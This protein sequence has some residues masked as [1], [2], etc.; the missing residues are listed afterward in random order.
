MP[1]S[2]GYFLFVK[3]QLSKLE[4]ITYRK[5]MGEYIVY[6][7]DKYIAGIYDDRLLVKPFEGVESFLPD[8]VFEK[9]Y[10]GAKDM[11][12][13]GV[14]DDQDALEALFD[15]AYEKLPSQKKKSKTAK[16]LKET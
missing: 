6:Y 10:D 13:V 7:K 11:L 5:M 15:A 8:I 4:N 3:E 16:Q 2:E 9:P 12:L 14:I 1:T